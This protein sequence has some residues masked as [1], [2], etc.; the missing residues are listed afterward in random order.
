MGNASIWIYP[1]HNGAYNEVA[2]LRQLGCIRVAP[3]DFKL[4]EKGFCQELVIANGAIKIEQG[5][6]KAWL[7]FAG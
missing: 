2:R 4:G 1:A 7:W 6:F 3:V 5:Y